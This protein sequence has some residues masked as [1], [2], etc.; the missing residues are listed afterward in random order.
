MDWAD[1]RLAYFTAGQRHLVVRA[2]WGARL[3][4]DL[5]RLR[6]IGPR[7]LADDLH[8]TECEL[9]LR[10]SPETWRSGGTSGSFHNDGGREMRRDSP[11]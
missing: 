4:V 11:Y 3:V 6:P 7:E 1:H 5:D 9:I 8:G 2:W 10:T